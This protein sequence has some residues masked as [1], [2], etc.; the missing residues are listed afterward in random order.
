M[1]DDQHAGAQG[2]A[3]RAHPPAERLRPQLQPAAALDVG[4]PSAPHGRTD[5]CAAANRGAPPPGRS[6]RLAVPALFTYISDNSTPIRHEGRATR[7]T[8]AE[9]LS[10]LRSFAHI[11]GPRGAVATRVVAGSF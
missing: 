2:C 10:F 6:A 1:R 3:I 7:A 9:L 8:E 11:G 5:P 4:A